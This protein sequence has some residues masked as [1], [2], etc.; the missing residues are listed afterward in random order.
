M[1]GLEAE[2]GRQAW[3]AVRILFRLTFQAYERSSDCVATTDD[4]DDDDD[5]DM[6]PDLS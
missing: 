2:R 4:D 5:F 3:M 6:I 1:P